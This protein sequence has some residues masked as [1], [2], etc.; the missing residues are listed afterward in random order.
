MKRIK[1]YT[2]AI[3]LILSVCAVTACRNSGSGNNPSA[4]SSSGVSEST[5]SS[6]GQ[7]SSTESSRGGSVTGSDDPDEIEGLGGTGMTDGSD[8]TGSGVDTDNLTDSSKSESKSS[9]GVIGGLMD[10]VEKDV[11]ELMDGTG[12]E[13][14]NA[15]EAE[16]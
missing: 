1:I 12:A 10:D 2:F 11:D 3:L 14:H 7:G 15:D 8:S 5:G 16:R 9:T 4:S 13:S 6:S